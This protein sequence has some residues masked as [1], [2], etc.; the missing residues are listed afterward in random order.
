[1]TALQAALLGF[2]GVFSL[3]SLAWLIQWRSGNAGIVDAFWSWSLGGLGLFY[4]LVGSAPA[5]QRLALGLMAALWSLRLGLHIFLRNHGK[6]EDRRYHEFRERWGA[7]ANRN[8]FFFF[9]FQTLFAMLLS[10][11]FLVAAFNSTAVPPAALIL[12][13]LIWLLSVCGEGIA[14]RQMER[15]RADPAK[16]GTVC[17]D[18]LWRYSRHPNYFFESLHWLAYLPLAWGSPWW[19]AALAS[20]LIMAWLLTK[21]SGVPILERHMLASKPGYAEYMR[22]TSV[23]IPWPPKQT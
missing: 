12:A 23:L 8:F 4:A 11:A 18:G 13:A 19:W 6:P 7:Q 20:P 3:I 15:F 21:M 16:K 10:T 1:M 9:H 2:A 14:D 17:R 5:P 22:S